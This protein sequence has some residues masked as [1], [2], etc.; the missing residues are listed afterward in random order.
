MGVIFGDI[1]FV[2]IEGCCCCDNVDIFIM[3]LYNC[4]FEVQCWQMIII[5]GD[6]IYNIVIEGNFDDCQ[7]MVKVSFVDQ[8]FFKGI[9]LVVVNLINWV[10][11]MVQIV[12][13]FYVVLQFG[14]LYCLVV[15]LVLIGN[16]GDI[17]VGYLVC[18]MGLLVSQLI[19]V[20]N[21]NDILYC[22][23]SG[24]CYDKDILYFLLLLLM[25]I[26]V[27]FNFE[28][29]LFDL[30]GCNGKVVVELLDVFKV[31]GK[32]LVEDQCWIEVC[33]LFDFLVV[34][35]EQICEIIVEVYCFCGELFDLYIVIG[36]C[37]VCEC[38]CSLSVLMVILGIVYLVKFFEVVEKVGIG[39]VLVLFVYFVDLFECE[40]CCI[41][42]LNELV[43]VQVFVSQ[44]GNCG[45]LF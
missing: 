37:V 42:L 14:V 22:F 25:D 23:M 16:F 12:Y 29:L 45:K 8:G 19:V 44:Y 15:F 36:V 10:W 40:E 34:S 6:N 39:Q 27:L 24:N 18:N 38:W 17:F 2:V 3:Y 26:M 4:V 20:I 9:C 43:K 32:L 11:I 33:K 1:G 35:D 31:S 41:V 13:Y 5:F 30:Y 28:C 21:C 7:E